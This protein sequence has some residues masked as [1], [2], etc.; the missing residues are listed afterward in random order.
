MIR[1]LGEWDDSSSEAQIRNDISYGRDWISKARNFGGAAAVTIVFGGAILMGL[2][3][4][5]VLSSMLRW[6]GIV[7]SVTGLFFFVVGKIAESK[8]PGRLAEV[9]ETGANKVSDVPPSVID[10][11]GDI[12]ISFGSQLTSGLAGPSLSLLG[13]GAIL[14]GASFLPIVIKRFIPFVK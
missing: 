5:P 7:L 14:I 1:Q 12:F 10:L 3:F 2:V 6:P 11:G 13:L 8:A 4:L 9:V